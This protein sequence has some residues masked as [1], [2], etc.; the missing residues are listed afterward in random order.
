MI[1]NDRARRFFGATAALIGAGLVLQLILTLTTDSDDTSFASSGGRLVNFFCFFT[2]LSN[3][4][5]MVTTAL[6]ARR[7][8]R[9]STIFRVFRI[10]G[11]L[12]IAVTG[13][14]FHIALA[15]LH[16]LTGWDWLADRLLHLL[17]PIL[18]PLGWLLYGPRRQID[19][20]IVGLCVLPPIAWLIFT[21]IR[22]EVVQDRNG[23]D[24]Y[25]YPFL[26]VQEHGY[27]VVL[28]NGAVVAVLFLVLAAGMLWLDGRL[29]D[30]GSEEGGSTVQRGS[31]P[32]A[33]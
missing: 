2:V 4:A 24:Y 9:T 31:R 23:K 16:E 33:L 7:L 18:G 22:G 17:G 10:V 1:R 6:L 15:D 14:V 19:R 25:P 28:I 8:E 3:I 30:R 5:V 26:D 11:V 20:R 21:L 32:T 27:V 29:A 13:I 12:G